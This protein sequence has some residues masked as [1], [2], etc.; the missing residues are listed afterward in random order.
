MLRP[1]KL[2]ADFVADKFIRHTTARISLENAAVLSSASLRRGYADVSAHLAAWGI[3]AAL[4]SLS[5]LFK[6]CP[7]Y[8]LENIIKHHFFFYLFLKSCTVIE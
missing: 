7:L 3:S 6:F 5:P 4:I 1:K 2:Y 8:I